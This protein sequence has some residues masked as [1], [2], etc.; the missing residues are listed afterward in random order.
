MKI[1]VLISRHLRSNIHSYDSNVSKNMAWWQVKYVKVAYID[2]KV[3]DFETRHL[4]TFASVPRGE[5]LI[6]TKVRR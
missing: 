2:K 3:A 6:V 1:L 5:L 4:V